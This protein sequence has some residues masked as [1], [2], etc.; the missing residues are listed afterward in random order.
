MAEP[1]TVEWIDAG[2][3]AQCQPNAAYPEG[4]DLLER[5]EVAAHCITLL[6]YPAPRCGLW[7]VRCPRCRKSTHITATGRV[8]DPRSLSMACFQKPEEAGDGS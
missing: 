8:D 5:P 7:V 2:R 4:V 3:E 6:P 1:L